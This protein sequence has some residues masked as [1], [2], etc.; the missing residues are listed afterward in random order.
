[1]AE[2]AQDLLAGSGWLPE[3]LRTLGQAAIRVAAIAGANAE[4]ATTVL[5][6]ADGQTTREPMAE[7]IDEPIEDP[8]E[9]PT[10]S[11]QSAAD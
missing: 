6:E 11:W 4:P 5:A 9:D 7:P 8:T 3:P 2:Q 1:M 10:G